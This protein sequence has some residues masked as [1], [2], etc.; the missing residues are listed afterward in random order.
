MKIG[1]ILGGV[2][3]RSKFCKKIDAL[4]PKHSGAACGQKEEDKIFQML[5]AVIVTFLLVMTR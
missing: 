5:M 4:R 1:A 3:D 2:D